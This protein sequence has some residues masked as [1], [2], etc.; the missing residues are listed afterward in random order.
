MS[1]DLLNQLAE[2]GAYHDARQGVVSVEDVVRRS[3]RI[4]SHPEPHRR[5]GDSSWRNA[6]VAALAAVLVLIVVGG[7]ALLIG[8]DAGT[9]P[10]VTRPSS[11]NTTLPPATTLPAAVVTTTPPTTVASTITSQPLPPVLV[12]IRVPHDE[13]IFGNGQMSSVAASEIGVVAVGTSRL[14]DLHS[15]V[16]VSLDGLTWTRL[17]LD[18]SVL[19]RGTLMRSVAAYDGGFVEVGSDDAGGDADAAVW[20]SPDGRGWTRVPHDESAFGGEADQFM[21]SVAAFDGGLVAVGESS[22]LSKMSAAMW[23]SP[24]G[25]SWTRVPPDESIFDD[26]VTIDVTAFD[27]GLAVVGIDVSDG[28][29]DAAVWTSADGVDWKRVSHDEAIFGGDGDQMMVSIASFD[30][31]LVAVGFDQV[32]RGDAAVWMSSDAVTWIRVPHDE[33]IFGAGE[34]GGAEMTSIEAFDTGLVAGGIE[35]NPGDMDAVVWTTSDGLTWM[36]VSTDATIFGGDDIQRIHSI[37]VVDGSLVAVGLQATWGGERLD[38]DPDA[39]VWNL[40]P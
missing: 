18:E 22:S 2:Y 28:D 38:T 40:T 17:P 20:V 9:S 10:V 26:A 12:G 5:A 19:G 11:P 1:T 14:A 30:G 35:Q 15:V 34:T 36:R 13:A 27:G 29:A 37:A 33:S 23:T 8:G 7:V 6:R 24:D 21:I 16:W 31:G 32:G 39:A 25:L 4:R 3:A